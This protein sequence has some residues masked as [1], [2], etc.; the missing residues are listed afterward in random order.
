MGSDI[1][2][3][4]RFLKAELALIGPAHALTV[5]GLQGLV[6]FL[7]LCGRPDAEDNGLSIRTT[8]EE[9][10][11]DETLKTVYRERMGG[12]YERKFRFEEPVDVENVTAHMENCLLYTSDA[13]DEEDSV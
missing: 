7:L 13:A 4:D 3:I 8:T 9:K 10:K 2:D 5:H 11:E 1:L 12:T 6:L